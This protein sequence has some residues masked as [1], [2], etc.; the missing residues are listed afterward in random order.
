[1]PGEPLPMTP[2]RLFL[3]SSSGSQ[4]LVWTTGPLEGTEAG[5]VGLY[6]RAIAYLTH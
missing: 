5:Y 4:A 3:Q 2:M 6:R 1:M